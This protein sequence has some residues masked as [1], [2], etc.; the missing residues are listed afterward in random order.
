MFCGIRLSDIFQIWIQ[1]FL[2][3]KKVRRCEAQAF[4][5]THFVY[6]LFYLASKLWDKPSSQALLKAV[7]SHKCFRNFLGAILTLFKPDP[8]IQI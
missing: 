7:N 1:P 3:L 2:Q 6:Y 5:A 8:Y 4:L